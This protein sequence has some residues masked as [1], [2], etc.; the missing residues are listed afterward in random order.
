M[1]RQVMAI[2]GS[3]VTIL[4]MAAAMHTAPA[5]GLARLMPVRAG[6]LHAT[7]TIATTAVIGAGNYAANYYGPAL[8]TLS[9]TTP[10]GA[11]SAE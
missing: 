4:G 7:T 8:R 6:R 11:T 9:N 5:I 1:Q 10:W 3:M 2:P